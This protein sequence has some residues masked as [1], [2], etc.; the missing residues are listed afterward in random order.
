M[1]AILSF[2]FSKSCFS[3]SLHGKWLFR[4]FLHTCISKGSRTAL[5]LAQPLEGAACGCG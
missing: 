5:L 1:A 2:I 4:A 3:P